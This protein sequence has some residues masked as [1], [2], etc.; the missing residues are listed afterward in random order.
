V[1]ALKNRTNMPPIDIKVSTAPSGRQHHCGISSFGQ[2]I[3]REHAYWRQ[4]SRWMIDACC[5]QRTNFASDWPVAAYTIG[6]IFSTRCSI[7]ASAAL[8]R[9]ASAGVHKISRAWRSRLICC[10]HQVR[11]STQLNAATIIFSFFGIPNWRS[12]YLQGRTVGVNTGVA[13]GAADL[14]LEPD[15]AAPSR[16]NCIL[17]Q[18]C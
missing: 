14:R 5:F 1:G 7:I 11:R 13:G 3:P 18:T 6:T 12:V 2:L 8:Q 17:M 16:Q 10:I 9:L 15:E 4:L